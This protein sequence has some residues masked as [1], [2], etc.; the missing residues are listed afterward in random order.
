[1]APVG[2]DQS[3]TAAQSALT[4]LVNRARLRESLRVPGPLPLDAGEG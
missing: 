3:G 1:M 4:P 2:A